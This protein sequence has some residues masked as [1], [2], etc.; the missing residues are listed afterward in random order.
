MRLAST[1]VIGLTIAC[2]S[3]PTL[4]QVSGVHLTDGDAILDYG[5]GTTLP[6]VT[7]GTSGNVTM[8][9][10]LGGS[11]LAPNTN[12]IASGNW[13]YRFDNTNMERQLADVSN[14]AI[15]T[16][17]GTNQVRYD[18][19]E[20]YTDPVAGVARG[21]I[22]PFTRAWT[23]FSVVDTGVDRARMAMDFCVENYG[24]QSHTIDIFAVLD[25]NAMTTV[26]ADAYA[27][28]VVSSPNR[29]LSITDGLG[30][31]NMIG[32]GADFGTAGSRASILTPMFN[33]TP[34]NFSDLAA[35]LPGNL[36]YAAVMQYS[37]QLDP[38]IPVCS[39][40]EVEIGIAPEPAT[41][42]LLIAGG[43]LIRRSK[44]R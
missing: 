41:L 33:T 14:N 6:T 16:L 40:V 38:G 3:M 8:N 44:L 34:T 23:N 10:Q 22:Q 42:A 11:W 15:M 27:P 43:W 9:F 20:L 37:K 25:I 21:V 12:W 30:F 28:V 19:P 29:T 4:A 18:Y 32:H 31:A 5:A 39:N 35:P 17:T 13:F 2:F 26:L 1:I 36:D 7:N 24:T